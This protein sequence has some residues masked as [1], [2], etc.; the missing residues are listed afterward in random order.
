[1]FSGSRVQPAQIAPRARLRTAI[2]PVNV[3]RVFQ[4]Y[5]HVE[6]MLP[7]TIPTTGQRFNSTLSEGGR[8][9]LSAPELLCDSRPVSY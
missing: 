1:M 2:T 7:S 8:A 6:Y 4:R 9:R 3:L 5:L